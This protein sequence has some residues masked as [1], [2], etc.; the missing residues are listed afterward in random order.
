M[1]RITRRVFQIMTA[2]GCK[3]VPLVKKI[4]YCASSWVH[5]KNFHLPY[6]EALEKQG[7]QVDIAVGGAH[8]DTGNKSVVYTP[9]KKEILSLSNIAAVFKIRKLIIENEYDIISTHTVLASGI[10]RLAVMLMR[11]KRP[12][13]INTSHGYFFWKGCGRLRY[14]VYYGI[15]RILKNVT[16]CIMTMNKE[17]FDHAK[18]LIKRGGKVVPIPGM[19]VDVERF[20]PPYEGEKEKI[21]LKMGISGS[22]FILLYAAE[23]SKR[24]NHFDLITAMSKIT[25]S[26]PNIKLYLAGSGVTLNECQIMSD[27]LGLSDH[28]IYLNWRDDLDVI[29]R[30]C[31][32]AVS[33]SLSEG[34]PFNI[35][36]A[37]ASSLPV[38]ASGIRGHTDLI[39]EGINGYIFQAG[40]IDE[41]IEKILGIYHLSDRGRGMGRNGVNTAKYFCFENAFTQIM[42]VYDEYLN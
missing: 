38:V 21:R 23:F 9:F 24:K 39:N 34:L 12:A 27:R 13:V 33:S 30:A 7:N 10:C 15:E 2:D 18:R 37:M 16:D 32:L 17:D 14:I 40:N 41:M 31:D 36:E 25:Q 5:I 35:L 1:T 11:K 6:I 20:R 19:G 3:G 26:E 8:S 28:I 42:S 29:I 22:D 4:L